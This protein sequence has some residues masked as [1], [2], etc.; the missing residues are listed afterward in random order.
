MGSQLVHLPQLN[1]QHSSPISNIIVF[2]HTNFSF[3]VSFST[4]LCHFSCHGLR[5]VE[6]E[7]GGG[8]KGDGGGGGGD[9]HDG[10]GH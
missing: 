5:S 4:Y 7:L 10:R 9:Q 8:G 2:L 1:H 3:L 6:N